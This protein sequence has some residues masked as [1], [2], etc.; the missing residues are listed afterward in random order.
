MSH[1]LM[2]TL[3]A[4][5]QVLAAASSYLDRGVELTARC[6]QVQQIE[7]PTGAESLRATWVAEQFQALGLHDVAQ[8]E[9]RNVYARV[10]GQDP[11]LPALMI[12]AHTDT[13]FPAGTDLAVHVDEKS[14]RVFGPGIGDNSTGVASLLALAGELVELQ[15]PID[16]WLVA[17]S[18][19]EGTG[20]LRGMR[21]AVDRLQARI[22]ASIVIEGTGLG[23]I[24]H[25]ALGSRRYRITANAPGGHSWSDFGSASAIH[26]LVQLANDIAR[27]R[28]PSKPR[29]TFNIGR[30]AGGTSI[31]SIAQ[32]ASLELDLRNEDLHALAQLDKQVQKIVRQ[33]Q[34]ERWQRWG[35]T[36]ETEV[37][38]DR[39]GGEIGHDHPLVVAAQ[40]ALAGAGLTGRPEL[41]ISST[42]ANIPLNRGIPCVCIGITQ[43][44]DAHRLEEWISPRY[45]PQGT[46]HLMLL[47]WWT[48]LWLAG[49]VG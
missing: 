23:R 33:F 29:T 25:R 35:V 20:D 17:N 46:Q 39:P 7:S 24:V 48:A 31:N 27:L 8:D 32:H 15:P 45:L 30:I 13:V 28:V 44:G 3:A 49:E 38:G 16:I 22:G 19:E 36:V 26:V 18:C 43:G 40:Q 9:Q 4:Y 1:D 12:S 21:A 5:P 14:G 41:Q 47:S 34:T 2:Q 11:T 6:V 37:I 42:D 10:P